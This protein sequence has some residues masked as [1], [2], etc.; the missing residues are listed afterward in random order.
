MIL[1]QQCKGSGAE[2]K[3]GWIEEYCYVCAVSTKIIDIL[4]GYPN[5]ISE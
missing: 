4:Y 3:K 2:P 5:C 1:I